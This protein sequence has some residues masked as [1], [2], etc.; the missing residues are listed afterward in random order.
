ME[1]NHAAQEHR[2]RSLRPCGERGSVQVGKLLRKS[3]DDD[4]N[5]TNY[6]VIYCGL[7]GFTHSVFPQ[8]WRVAENSSQR[9]KLSTLLLLISGSSVRTSAWTLKHK[10]SQEA[11]SEAL[12]R[13]ISHHR[14]VIPTRLSSCCSD[15]RELCSSIA[16]RKD[17]WKHQ[18]SKILFFV[19]DFFFC[20]FH[21]LHYFHTV[22]QR[23][24]FWYSDLMSIHTAS[25]LQMNVFWNCCCLSMVSNLSD[26]RPRTSTRR[27]PPTHQVTVIWPGAQHFDDPAGPKDFSLAYSLVQHLKFR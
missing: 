3:N 26:I 19:G 15:R 1:S 16:T 24:V 7:R 10:R 27:F 11:Q 17:D 23:A 21:L 12:Q 6:L 20:F 14:P 13:H 2:G 9:E 8:G 4:D 22:F 25:R 18:R 5:N